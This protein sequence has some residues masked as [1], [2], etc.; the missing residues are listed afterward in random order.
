MTSKIYFMTD[1]QHIHT[2]QEALEKGNIKATPNRLLVVKELMNSDLPLSLI[3][4][5]DRLETLDR[6]SI[7]RVLNLLMEKDVIHSFE[8]GRG[9]SKYEICHGESHCSLNDMHAHFYCEK[10]NK[11]FCFEDIAAPKLNIPSEFKIR[12][13]NY[14]LKGTCPDCSGS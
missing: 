12:T 3:E 6:S 5:E 4:L 8:D 13:V 11:V 9:V 10:C 2:A 14:M 7:S 1:H